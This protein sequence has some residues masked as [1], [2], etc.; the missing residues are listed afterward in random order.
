MSGPSTL[1]LWL[2]PGLVGLHLL[3]LVAVAACVAGGVWQWSSYA[4]RQDVAA[5]DR[6]AAD[7]PALAEVWAPGDGFTQDLINRAVV[8]E[9]EF[10]PSEEQV[11]VDRGDALWLL[12]PFVPA[13]SDVALLVVRGAADEVGE[14]PAVPAGPQ[15]LRVVLQGGEEAA[16]PID[17]RGVIGSVRV[18]A[19]LNELGRPLYSGFAISETPA[20]S[21]GLPLVDAP[22]PDVS[23]TVGLKNLAYALQWWVFGLFAV[24]MWWR[25]CTDQVAEARAAAE[26]KEQHA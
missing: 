9:G 23:W 18:P 20:A 25:M 2:R 4:D 22:V 16:A 26:Q 13:G 17:D 14:P 3:L 11:W 24:F 7:A 6:R 12:A 1:R 21:G 10:A 19:L 15:E 8:V 5:A